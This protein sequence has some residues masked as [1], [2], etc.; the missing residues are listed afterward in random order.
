MLRISSE[1]LLREGSP[2]VFTYEIE[3]EAE[4]VMSRTDRGFGWCQGIDDFPSYG[5]L[6]TIE[7]KI[8]ATIFIHGD[9][10]PKRTQKLRDGLRGFTTDLPEYV[11]YRTLDTTYR[12]QPSPEIMA[13]RGLEAALEA[14]TDEAS[15]AIKSVTVS[16]DDGLG[17]KISCTARP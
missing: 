15:I 9:P 7:V 8:I 1:L 10:S 3:A 12:G 2:L 13:H 17:P 16:L 14:Y 11:S 6:Q 4:R 5:S